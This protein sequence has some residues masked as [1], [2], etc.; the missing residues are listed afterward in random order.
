MDDLERYF[1][2]TIVGTPRR[3][4]L[5]VPSASMG[6]PVWAS[7][8]TSDG[9]GGFLASAGAW[10][11]SKLAPAVL[12][13]KHRVQTLR[14]R[15]WAFLAAVLVVAGVALV[16]T[17]I[18]Q[19]PATASAVAGGVVLEAAQP[20]EEAKSFPIQPA[21]DAEP[22]TVAITMQNT[23]FAA[24]SPLPKSIQ[25]PAPPA[26]PTTVQLPPVP[27]KPGPT[28]APQAAKGTDKEVATS[29]LIM[30]GAGTAKT[31]DKRVVEAPSRVAAAPVVAPAPIKPASAPAAAS[32]PPK[33]DEPKVTVV[34]IARDGSYVLITNPRT[35]LPERF[36]VGQKIFSGETVQKIDAAGGKVQLDKRSV[37]L[38]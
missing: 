22:K 30:D 6:E 15:H 4:T 17:R 13:M 34:D 16:G 26:P 25:P 23:P 11:S 38:Q 1:T 9:T 14:G 24:S 32:A 12:S 21:T 36:G 28:V 7:T 20:M 3:F 35:R 10:W 31:D 33:V 37:G 29:L 2:N 19:A 5:G 8:V 18:G 27:A